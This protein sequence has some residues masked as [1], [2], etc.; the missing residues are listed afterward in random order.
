MVDPSDPSDL[1][2]ITKLAGEARCLSDPRESIRIARLSNVFGPGDKSS[3]F[4]SEIVRNA[5]DSGQVHFLSGADAAKD[6]IALEEAVTALAAMP[7]QASSRVVNLASGT[8]TSNK[9]IGDIL[10][11]KLGSSVTYGEGDGLH[12][13]VIRT[14]RMREELGVVPREFASAFDA[15]LDDDA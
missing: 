12:F 4:L 9:Q 2:N 8:L 6:Y 13:P 10:N 5:R 14:S 7:V 1:Y 15:F 11:R 3:N